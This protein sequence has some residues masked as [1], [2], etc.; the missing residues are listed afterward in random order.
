[1]ASNSGNTMAT[2]RTGLSAFNK[3]RDESK[4]A[5]LWPPPVE[6]IVNFIAYLSFQGYAES[7][8]RAYVAS[9]GYECKIRGLDDSTNRF[10]VSKVLEGFKRLKS[11][12]DT[13]LPITEKVLARLIDTL[14][15]VCSSFYEAKLYKAAYTL[16]FFAFLRVGEFALSKGNNLHTILRVSDVSLLN[17]QLTL[18]LR[19]SKTDQLGRG[20]TIVLNRHGSSI[21]PVQAMANFL[22][23]RPQFMGPLFCHFGGKPLTRYQFSAVLDKAIIA[24]GLDNKYYKSH[25]FRI[26]AAS[27]AADRGFSDDDIKMAGRWKSSAFKTYIRSPLTQTTLDNKS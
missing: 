9:I 16:A 15:A 8:A 20:I 13:R 6:Q 24:I 7:T 23:I 5:I 25:S 3:F 22:Q 12:G 27:A 26:G 4:T 11:K 18:C 21:C 2:Y 17:N 14:D 1:M 10:V 19:C